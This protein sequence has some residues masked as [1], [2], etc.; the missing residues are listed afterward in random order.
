MRKNKNKVL[1]VDYLTGREH[2]ILMFLWKWKAAS[3]P[4]LK[5]AISSNTNNWNFYQN[6]GRLNKSGYI[7]LHAGSTS[8]EKQYLLW[9]L[10][11]KGFEYIRE[12]LGELKNETFQSESFF[13]DK[14]ALAL[15]LGNLIYHPKFEIDLYTH[16]EV[17]SYPM[18]YYPVWVPQTNVHHP[19][20]YTRLKDGNKNVII[21]HEVEMHLKATEQYEPLV[22]FYDDRTAI[23]FVLWLVAT[24][25]MA[26]R[27]ESA[28]ISR[29][30]RRRSIHHIFLIDDFEKHG[31]DASVHCGPQKPKKISELY[32][33]Y[34]YHIPTNNPLIP[35]QL[36]FEE[37][38]LRAIRSPVGLDSYKNKRK[39]LL[40]DSTT[41]TSSQKTSLV[42]SEKE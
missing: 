12:D 6:L 17:S 28:F 22:D 32:H 24:P 27:L 31:W 19:D 33:Q 37:V 8:T 15:Q 30:C 2:Q 26:E 5:Q 21:A 36:S 39:L 1:R 4:T 42:E 38:F 18:G 9:T 34:G 29:R 10:T 20:G 35:Q 23:T 16:K 3:Y 40:T 41:H 13:H 25:A 14:Y 7:E 11:E